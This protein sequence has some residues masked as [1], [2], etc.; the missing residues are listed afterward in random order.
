MT[1][2]DTTT[3]ARDVAARSGLTQK[4]AKKAVDALNESLAEFLKAGDDVE[5]RGVG[6]LKNTQA[7]ARRGVHPTTGADIQI[8]ARRR[9][10]FK[11]SSKLKG[12]LQ[13]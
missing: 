6:T 5:L 1:K 2:I 11:I 7:A 8:P 12:S 4:D 13:Q 9:V 3:L 10:S